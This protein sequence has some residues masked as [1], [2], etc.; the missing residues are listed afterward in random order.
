MWSSRSTDHVRFSLQK[1]VHVKVEI[2][3]QSHLPGKFKSQSMFVPM[4]YNVLNSFKFIHSFKSHNQF[5]D[6][7]CFKTQFSDKHAKI[8]IVT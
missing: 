5:R 7:G 4:S 6:W 2:T 8:Q 1:A 3:P